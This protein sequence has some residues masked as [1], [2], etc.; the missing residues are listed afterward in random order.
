MLW[1]IRVQVKDGIYCQIPVNSFPHGVR[2]VKKMSDISNQ[3]AK[4]WMKRLTLGIDCKYGKSYIQIKLPGA[5]CREQRSGNL[6]CKLLIHTS[7]MSYSAVL[8]NSWEGQ[9]NP[10]P[11]MP[12]AIVTPLW[13]LQTIIFVFLSI[14]I[15]FFSRCFFLL[16]PI[17]EVVYWQESLTVVRWAIKHANCLRVVVLLQKSGV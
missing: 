10:S 16:L 3:K 15:A 11:G 2:G 9:G 5:V 4:K 12:I 8:I 13:K 14:Q 6:F 1:N 7:F 17:R